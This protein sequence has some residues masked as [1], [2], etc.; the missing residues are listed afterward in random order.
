MGIRCVDHDGNWE[1]EDLR[2]HLEDVLEAARNSGRQI[3]FDEEGSFTISY[4]RHAVDGSAKR[5]LAGGGPD[6]S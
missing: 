1:I 2:S 3:V 5:Y 6:E 4:K